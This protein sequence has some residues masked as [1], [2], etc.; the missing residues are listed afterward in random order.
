MK[1]VVLDGYTLNPGDLDWGPLGDLVDELVVHEHTPSG[2]VVERARG[3]RVL[4]T[5]K[6]VLDRTA[7]GHLPDA[8]YIGVLATGYN[9]VDLA[10]ARERG[11]TVTNVPSY[12]TEAVVQMVFALLFALVRRVEHHSARVKGGAWAESRDF[13]FWDTPQVDLQALKLGIVG[14]GEIGRAVGRVGEAFG[15]R[16]LVNSRTRPASLPGGFEY[17]SFDRLIRE[18]DVLTLH[19]PLTSENRHLINAEVLGKMKSRAFLI[20]TGRGPLVDEAALA[21]ALEAGDIAGAALDVMEEE[22]PPADSPLYKLEN[23]LITPH[24]AWA[25]HTARHRLME[26]AAGNLEAW[27]AGK[28]VNVVH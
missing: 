2:K 9:V 19:C 8:K 11:I 1:A 15:M 25:T 5:N 20:N 4:L 10:A 23:C 18:C 21:E 13:C 14:Y 6:T 16:V 28:A 3:A 22:P 12:G 17:H 26:I 7:L 24:I 27:M